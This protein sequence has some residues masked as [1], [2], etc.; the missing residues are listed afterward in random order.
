MK[1]IAKTSLFYL[2][3]SIPILILS[4]F[5][6]YYIVTKEVKDGNNELLL[7]RSALIEQYLKENDTIAL[8]LIT[9]VRKR[10][11]KPFP[12]LILNQ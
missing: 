9:K 3:S 10:K 5:V 6:C 2:L 8:H 7:N 1:L 12:N 11:L 4:G